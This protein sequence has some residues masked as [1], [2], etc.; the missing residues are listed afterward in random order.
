MGGV[1]S[2]SDFSQNEGAAA[3]A[4]KGTFVSERKKESNEPRRSEAKEERIFRCSN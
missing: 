3:A 2:G 4:Q 1:K